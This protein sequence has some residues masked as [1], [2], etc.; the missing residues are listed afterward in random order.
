MISKPDISE[1][2]QREGIELLRK[3][4]LCW[5][6]CPLH[7]EK[8]PSFK[9]DP[10]RQTFHCFGCGAGGD[11]ISFI[12][13][14]RQLP[15]KEALAYLGIHND[16]P[17]RSDLRQTKKQILIKGFRRRCIDDSIQLVREYRALK[18]IVAEIRTDA[19]LDL[20]AWAYHEI[21]VL[22]YKLDVLCY[23]TDE[24]RYLLFK[25]ATNGTTI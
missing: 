3:G 2:L 15:F 11:V 8:T 10:E 5:A 20:R 13:A 1:V 17:H 12:Q 24:A 18:G 7:I 16:K 22:E 19:D 25:E 9:V 14:F 23:G 4:R 6:C 21:P